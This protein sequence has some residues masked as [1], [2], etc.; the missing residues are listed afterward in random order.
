MIETGAKY[1]INDIY[2]INK[3]KGFAVGG[4]KYFEG[5]I[6]K[7]LDGGLTW[8]KLKD[9]KINTTQDVKLQT[10]YSIDF[11]NENI[12]QIVG[13]G[14]KILRTEDG[15][16]NWNSIQN[17]T[18]ENFLKIKMHSPDS[19]IL[20]ATG[21]IFKSNSYW[22]FFDIDDF[23]FPLRD[24]EFTNKNTAYIAGYGFVKKSTDNLKTWKTLNIKG[25]YFYDI[26]FVN[27]NIGFICGWQGGVYK[28]TD[29]GK[30]W[31][32]IRSVNKIFSKRHHYE[33]IDFI[34]ENNGIVCGYDGEILHT[35]NG[36]I[37]WK[38]IKIDTNTDFH[39]IYFY[40][41]NTVFVGGSE[42]QIFEIKL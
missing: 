15:G 4:D 26:D 18:W 8:Y 38:K 41:I 14:G 35:N 9:S 31:A 24:I 16:D 19:T 3:N 25:D 27:E 11:Y 36:G 13:L 39:S 21:S 10:L 29:A 33:N 42:G 40:D 7:T 23:T 28:T 5:D 2:F 32:S 22:Y 17:G 30:T 20:V 34:N 37:S 12:G 1:R 6:I